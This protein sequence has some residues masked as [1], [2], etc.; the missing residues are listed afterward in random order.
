MQDKSPELLKEEDQISLRNSLLK[1][2]TAVLFILC[3][4]FLS[5]A[6][7]ILCPYPHILFALCNS[8]SSLL[9]VDC[10]HHGAPTW[11]PDRKGIWP[12]AAA[13]HLTQPEEQFDWLHQLARFHPNSSTASLLPSQRRLPSRAESRSTDQR[14][15]RLG[16]ADSPTVISFHL[17]SSI[18][19]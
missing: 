11:S 10:L 12:C 15:H 17:S 5:T 8:I 19:T 13:I 6:P 2:I 18:S 1:S 7:D 16:N 3:V 14:H 4:S 9:T